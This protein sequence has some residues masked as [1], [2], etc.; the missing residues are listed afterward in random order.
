MD[1]CY[2][3]SGDWRVAV[4]AGAVPYVWHMCVAA[5]QPDG[6]RGDAA[7]QRQRELGCAAAAATVAAAMCMVLMCVCSA[8][9]L[10]DERVVH[11]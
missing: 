4:Y 1:G 2:V 7:S 5:D 8:G 6:A 11:Y 9:H 3:Q 10:G